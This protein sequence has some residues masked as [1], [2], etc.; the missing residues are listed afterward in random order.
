MKILAIDPGFERVGVAILEKTK[1]PKHDLIYS[2]CFKTSKSL[3]FHLRL[4]LIGT[5]VEKIIK[6]YKP[7]ALAIEKLYFTTNQKTAMGVA[8]ARGVIIYCASHNGLDIFEY[9]PPQIKVAVTG[10]GK[11]DKNMVINMVPKLINIDKKTKS[12]DELDA[13]AIGITC[14]ACEKNFK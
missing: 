11:A 5:E 13:I 2:D 8:E 10:Y 9:T 7:K 14:L 4:S 12:D 3:E 1:N 6:K